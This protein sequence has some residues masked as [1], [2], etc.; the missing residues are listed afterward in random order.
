[1]ET[2]Q[3]VFDS[4]VSSFT[5]GRF[6][7]FVQMRGSIPAHWSQDIG[8]KMVPKPPIGIDLAD[9]YAERKKHES[10]LTEEYTTAI[11]TLNQFLPPKHR[12]IY[13]GFDMARTNKMKEKNVLSKLAGISEQVFAKT[14]FFMTHQPLESCSTTKKPISNLVY[15]GCQFGRL[16]TGVVRI[17]CVD[18]LD[19]TNT[20]QF[21]LGK[22]AL[23]HQVNITDYL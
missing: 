15:E 19:R 17:N 1:V 5:K 20:A 16:Q 9:P 13:V 3:I 12:I 11:R 8:A 21:A 6:T 7:S 2:E 14:G 23:A 18:C 4:S 22:C 10:I